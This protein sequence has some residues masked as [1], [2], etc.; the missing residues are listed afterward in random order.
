MQNPYGHNWKRLEIYEQGNLWLWEGIC[1]HEGERKAPTTF[2]S[3]DAQKWHAAVA[4][5]ACTSFGAILEVSMWQWCPT[6][7]IDRLII[8]NQPVNSSINQVDN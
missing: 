4:P 5:S 8:V 7:E 1:V 2:W 3:Y 6:E